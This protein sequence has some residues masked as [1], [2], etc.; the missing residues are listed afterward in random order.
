M[1][2]RRTKVNKSIKKIKHAK[3]VATTFGLL[4]LYM[5]CVIV[6]ILLSSHHANAAGQFISVGGGGPSGGGG[7]DYSQPSWYC[8]EL[9]GMW[10][11]YDIADL[12]KTVGGTYHGLMTYTYE[13][14]GTL[15]VPDKPGVKGG[16]ISGCKKIGATQIY[17]LALMNVRTSNKH[18]YIHNNNGI[19]QQVGLWPVKYFTEV[20]G[21]TRLIKSPF[22]EGFDV[23]WGTAEKHYNL[24]RDKFDPDHKTS[25]DW[26]EAT[27][28]CWNPNW[29]GAHS[30]FEGWSSV[31]YDGDISATT[32][33]DN[34]DLEKTIYTNEDEIKVTFRHQISYIKAEAKENPE[35]ASFTS[36]TTDWK[37]KRTEGDVVLDWEGTAAG[38]HTVEKGNVSYSKDLPA[39]TVNEHTRTIN[40]SM[41]APGEA[42]KICSTITYQNKNIVWS[43]NNNN[44]TVDGTAS[45]G[46][47]QSR[48]CVTVIRSDIEKPE[49]PGF[50]FKS[51]SSAGSGGGETSGIDKAWLGDI[52]I[53]SLDTTKPAAM[54]DIGFKYLS[55]QKY[56]S[57]NVNISHTIFYELDK[58][59]KFDSRDQIEKPYPST[60]YE[61]KLRIKKLSK[62]GQDYVESPWD[63]QNG[64]I[65]G[66]YEVQDPKRQ[67]EATSIPHNISINIERG[68]RALVC[69]YIKY[70]PKWGAYKLL[71]EVTKLEFDFVNK[72]PITLHDYNIYI[73]DPSM[74]AKQGGSEACVLV[75][76]GIGDPDGTPWSR[77]DPNTATDGNPY[78][79]PMYAGERTNIG[80]D[81]NS[82]DSA[83]Y[84]IAKFEAVN[85]V[86]DAKVGVNDLKGSS[87]YNKGDSVCAFIATKGLG[88]QCEGIPTGF[89]PRSYNNYDANEYGHLDERSDSKEIIAPN[90]V[91][92]KHA[93]TVGYYIEVYSWRCVAYCKRN[94]PDDP[95]PIEKWVHLGY[96]DDYYGSTGP[97]QDH[98]YIFDAA[99]RP[100]LKKPTFSVW[101]GGI[102]TS[103]GINT[104]TAARYGDGE[105]GIVYEPTNGQNPDKVF[106][107]W[108]EY[109]AAIG[110][111]T[112]TFTSGSTLFGGFDGDD[113]D[114][115][116]N[117][118]LTISNRSSSYVGN[119]GIESNDILRQRI[120]DYFCTNANICEETDSITTNVISTS[121]SSVYGLP[122]KVFYSTGD[123]NIGSDVERID[124]WI[125]AE[126]KVNTCVELKATTPAKSS[127]GGS[128]ACSKHLQINGPVIAREIALN[129]TYGA[130][131][132][133]GDKDKA[134]SSDDRAATAEVFN[135]SGA[136]T[137]LWGY[138][139]ATRLNSGFSEAYSRELPPRY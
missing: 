31:E 78:D 134:E 7:C 37:I 107:S 64:V 6:P 63:V 87:S 21:A 27:M 122:G 133:N 51:Q 58:N 3:H 85:F 83:A 121:A 24:Y 115:V 38:D 16:K 33:P 72:Q 77:N 110:G 34:M 22:S 139:Q 95:D 53:K 18:I 9:G 102:F 117:S 29:E 135:L 1:N 119:S 104:S 36:A 88:A 44:H 11:V 2:Q 89:I 131:S 81:V 82:W 48:A 91:G 43:N 49:N 114:I 30:T 109:L 80:W 76:A 96:E 4:V 19:P 124:A 25:V 12:E 126:G 41:L 66:T 70:T 14:G 125:I 59:S 13:D 130:D 15:I 46:Q 101:N 17:R 8:S 26:L 65:K 112:G 75:G 74:Y 68:E 108:G 39:S 93:V 92:A 61:V 103:G 42:R 127:S 69:S 62:K 106:G 118:P 23:D 54:K 32:T 116:E 71:K 5:I 50:E 99:S 73:V 138:A 111:S 120:I 98:W 57:I 137:Y 100:V 129:R 86:I 105:S 94:D 35:S 79:D 113:F 90:E 84:R 10:V 28:F 132:T 45:N 123:I 52:S 47:G 56:G 40:I 67:K 20:G 128:A 60:D 136:E 97:I 55:P